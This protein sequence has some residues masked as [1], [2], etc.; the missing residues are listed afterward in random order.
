RSRIKLPDLDLP[1]GYSIFIKVSATDAAST[2]Y[3]SGPKTPYF[4]GRTDLLDERKTRTISLAI[5][6]PS[7]S[8]AKNKENDKPS[9]ELLIEHQPVQF[10]RQLVSR[11]PASMD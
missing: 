5:S 8:L 2:I 10:L 3:S 1:S 9:I 11:R 7:Q 4:T 6:G